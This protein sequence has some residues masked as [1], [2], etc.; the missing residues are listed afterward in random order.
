MKNQLRKIRETLRLPE[1]ILRSKSDPDVTLYYKFF[2]KT[3]IGSKY[4]CVVVKSIANDYFILTTYFT[5]TK[6]S[7]GLIW[8]KTKK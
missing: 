7:G 1:C 6:I 3:V 2:N 8:R 5:D 4:L